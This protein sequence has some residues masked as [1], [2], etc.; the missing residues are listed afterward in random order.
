MLSRVLAVVIGC[1]L[2]AGLLAYLSGREN[3]N[4]LDLLLSVAPSDASQA[5]DVWTV[6]GTVVDRKSKMSV[7]ASVTVV[8][9]D[10]VTGNQVSQWVRSSDTGAFSLDIQQPGDSKQAVPEQTDDGERLLTFTVTAVKPT[11][12]QAARA[13]RQ[14]A[15]DDGCG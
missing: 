13:F 9:S 15:A 3:P 4:T 14:G 10:E 12:G 6:A 1:C 7:V 11:F 5:D 2:I 8:L